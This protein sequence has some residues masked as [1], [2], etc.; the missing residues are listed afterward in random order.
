METAGAARRLKAKATH[1][2]E[3]PLLERRAIRR[4]KN[5]RVPFRH[6]Q[7]RQKKGLEILLNLE[8]PAGMSPG[9]GGGIED[10]DVELLASPGEPRKHRHHVVCH[11]TML[12]GRD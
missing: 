11:E 5:P 6:F 4:K 2:F 8:R 3:R 9:E 12:G 10:D 7:C 1:H